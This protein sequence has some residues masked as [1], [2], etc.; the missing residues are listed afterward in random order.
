MNPKK[1][2]ISIALSLSILP[3]VQAA[4]ITVDGDLSD[5]GLHTNGNINDW[6]AS[7]SLGT[8]LK[9]ALEDDNA[10]GRGGQAYDAEALYSFMDATNLYIALVTGLDPNRL[11]DPSQNTYGPGDLAIDFTNFGNT[12]SF[13]FG[14]QTTGPDQGKI[15]QDVSWGLGLWDVNDK[16]SKKSGLPANP[17]HPTS[18]IEGTGNWVGNAILEYTETAF[19][20]MGEYTNNKH[21][22]IEA[23]IPLVAFTGFSGAFTLHWTMNCANDTIQLMSSLPALGLITHNRTSV[24][25]PATLALIALGMLGLTTSQR[26]RPTTLSA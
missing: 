21:Y 23:A 14:I 15:Y 19:K 9:R 22:V 6:T 4:N 5:W 7:S 2:L 11:N 16:E 8:S 18:I 13:E 10:P 25:E 20:N 3:V 17:N 24:P 1:I 12:G 26:K